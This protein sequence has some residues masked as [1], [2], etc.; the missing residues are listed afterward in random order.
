MPSSPTIEE[1][2]HEALLDAQCSAS[3]ATPATV[4][5]RSPSSSTLTP[6]TV[7]R[8]RVITDTQRKSLRDYFLENFESKPSQKDLAGL[9]NSKYDHT[10][11][12]SSV[13]EILSPKWAYLDEA[14]GLNRLEAKKR[15]ASYWPDLE[16]ALFCWYRIQLG[17]GIPSTAKTLKETASVFWY[18]FPQYRD[19][20]EPCWSAGWF[21]AFMSR[22]RMTLVEDKALGEVILG[23]GTKPPRR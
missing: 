5:I 21:Y 11:S 16:D 22:Y 19:Q 12:Q 6:R 17:K 1:A 9:F 20:Q 4:P 23:E 15:K 10:I 8:R 14:Q 7:K 3:P 13:S 18:S 2:L